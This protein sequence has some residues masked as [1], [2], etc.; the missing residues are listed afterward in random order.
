MGGWEG[1]CLKKV[2]D[3]VSE[4]TYKYLSISS[5]YSK[6]AARTTAEVVTPTKQYWMN[7][8]A[9]PM[10]RNRLRRKLCSRFDR[11]SRLLKFLPNTDR[12]SD[13][14][15]P[16]PRL[17]PKKE[18]PFGRPGLTQFYLTTYR[19]TCLPQ[20]RSASKITLLTGKDQSQI[21]NRKKG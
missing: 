6:F 4:S 16:Y 17:L 7:P 14:K 10:L 11:E 18:R 8:R 21:K 5:R 15:K 19:Y 2:G 12:L 1:S 9:Q 13:G 20:A 3:L